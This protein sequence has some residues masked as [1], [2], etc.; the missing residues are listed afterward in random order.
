[1]S[2]LSRVKTPKLDLS[3]PI[4]LAGSVSIKLATVLWHMLLPLNN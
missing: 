2:Y 3:D 4:L 1:M